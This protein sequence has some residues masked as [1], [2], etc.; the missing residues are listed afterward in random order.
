MYEQKARKAI[1]Q[2]EKHEALDTG[3]WN[4]DDESSALISFVSLGKRKVGFD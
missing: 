3:A 2:K 4:I 1:S